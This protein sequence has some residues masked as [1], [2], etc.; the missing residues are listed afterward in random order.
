MLVLGFPT[1][2]YRNSTNHRKMNKM[3]KKKTETVYLFIMNYFDRR[4]KCDYFPEHFLSPSGREGLK[5]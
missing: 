4:K 1:N 3:N 2:T 5:C